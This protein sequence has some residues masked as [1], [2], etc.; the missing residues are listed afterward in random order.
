M[1]RVCLKLLSLVRLSGLDEYSERIGR[2]IGELKANH[3]GT[4]RIAARVK[5]EK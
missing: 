5:A 2:K 3:V 4:A 1:L